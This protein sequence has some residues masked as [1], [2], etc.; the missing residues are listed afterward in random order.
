M[1]IYAPATVTGPERIQQGF[2]DVPSGC[3]S[4]GGALYGFFWTDHCAKGHPIPPA[5]DAPLAR[6][7]GDERC[8]ETDARNS[9]GRGM[10]ARSGDD[11]RTFSHAVE[12]P[13]GFVYAIA[14]NAAVEQPDGQGS[15]IFI[16]GVPRY[17]AGI[18]YMAQAT[19][20]NF[21][22]PHAWR[23]FIGRD[24]AG[25]A[26]WVSYQQWAG[27]ASPGSNWHPPA[28]AS[29]IFPSADGKQAC[30][31]EFSITWNKPLSRWLMVYN[32]TQGI[33]ARVAPEPW[34]PWSQPAV[35]LGGAD[36]VRCKI[37]MSVRGCG[38]RRDFWP[39]RRVGMDIVSG[40]FYAPFVLNRYTQAG[41]ANQAILYWLVSTWNPYE[42]DVMRSTLEFKPQ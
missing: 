2:F 14:V 16:F 23:F 28:A 6:P 37:V 25:H 4:V 32:C 24:A 18:P 35:M 12:M 33:V 11:G 26:K 20:A 42:V 31:G 17:R 15:S 34:G 13:P 27:G 8:P 29:E 3:V 22:D 30:V 5:P 40:G 21:S 38:D 9:I 19:P 36:D 10:M 41:K 39:G 7:A 1:K